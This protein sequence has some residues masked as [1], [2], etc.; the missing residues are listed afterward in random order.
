[1]N[2]FKIFAGIALIMIGLSL[3]NIGSVQNTEYAGVIL[4]GPFPIV[5]AS[6]PELA[7]FMLFLAAGLIIFTF[8]LFAMRW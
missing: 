3:L 8:L 2:P 5:F 7:T 1:M 6:N 4:I